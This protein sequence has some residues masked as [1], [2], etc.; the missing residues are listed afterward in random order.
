MQDFSN[1]NFS[2]I[3]DYCINNVKPNKKNIVDL[4]KYLQ[5]KYEAKVVEVSKERLNMIKN[6]VVM[7]NHQH[8]L[9]NTKQLDID[10][11]KAQKN[12]M[13][14]IM[15]ERT[16]QINDLTVEELN[17]DIVVMAIV[18]NEK[19]L[20]LFEDRAKQYG[21]T[22]EEYKEEVLWLDLERNNEYVSI[23][24]PLLQDEIRLFLGLEQSDLD[25]K[26]S[27]FYQYVLALQN[28]YKNKYTLNN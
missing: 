18:R 16:Q 11:T 24:T 7:L 4:E 5:D 21:L 13:I 12:E 14:S 27:R 20:K 8:L 23:T 17:L 3:C 9:T 25:N 15:Q 2:E 26:T 28:S 22:L 6:N 10:T 19:S 1:M